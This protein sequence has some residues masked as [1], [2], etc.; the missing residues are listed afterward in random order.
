MRDFGGSGAVWAQTA[1]YDARFAGASRGAAEIVGFGYGGGAFHAVA[2]TQHAPRD[3]VT[4]A[5]QA[6]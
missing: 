2:G 4:G 6:V 3:F 1:G 5:K